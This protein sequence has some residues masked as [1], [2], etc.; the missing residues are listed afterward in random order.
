ME[1]A[2]LV[3]LRAGAEAEA[4]FR[5]DLA[6][7]LEELVG[8]ALQIVLG[9]QIGVGRHGAHHDDVGA[10]RVFMLRGDLGHGDLD[11]LDVVAVFALVHE[12]AVDQQQAARAQAALELVDRR[13]VH[14]HEDVDLLGAGAGDLLVGELNGAVGRAAAHLGAVGRIPQHV[15]A[16]L[17]AGLCQDQTGGQDTPALTEA[18]IAEKIH[19][20]IGAKPIS[21][22]AAGKKSAVII[23]DDITRPTPCEPI[24]KAVIAELR[25]AGVPKE[26]IWFIIALDTHGVM[27]RTEFVRKLGEEIVENYEVHN[28]NLFFNHVFV[29]NTTNNVP[30]EINA[31]VMSADYKIAIGTTMAHSYYGFSGGAKCILP[32]V[33]SLRTI[34]RNH[35][36]TTTTEFNMGNPHTLMRSD[37]EQAARMMGLDFKIDAILNGHAQICNLF[38]GDFEAEIQ[39]AAAY[40][41]EHYAAKFVPDCDVVIANNYFKP[42]EANCAY[43]PEVIASL[44]D[45]GSFVLAANSPFGP[46]VHFLYDKWGHSAPG[47]MMWSGCYTKGKNMAHA[48]VFAEHTVKGMR[49]PWYIDEHSGAEYVKTWSDALRILDDGTPKKVVLYPNAECQVLDNSKQF[50]KQ[51][52]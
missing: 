10:L 37:A 38:A 19:A 23:I 6:L 12:R 8:Q 47:G 17:H 42:A 16:E 39:H 11:D 50:Y 48:V 13:R 20:A 40:A 21:E 43:T 29:G 25:A 46:C 45:G 14:G 30:V 24:A 15:H 5:V 1:F 9:E 26:N 7:L 35:S 2:G 31:D 27:Y 44:K 22:G 36:F 4:V 18:Q 33:S 51:G 49:D 52:K 3:D 28:H 32:G 41:A 34:M